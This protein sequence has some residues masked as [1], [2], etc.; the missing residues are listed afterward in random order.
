MSIFSVFQ[1]ST[2][3]RRAKDKIDAK[4]ASYV[5]GF[6]AGLLP[7][8]GSGIGLMPKESSLELR[9]GNDTVIRYC[10]CQVTGIYSIDYNNVREE[11]WHCRKHGT[12]AQQGDLVRVSRAQQLRPLRAQSSRVHS[13]CIG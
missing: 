3:V 7:T 8:F 5:E 11:N 12:R 1:I 10:L 4:S 6:V 13:L 9:E 2:V